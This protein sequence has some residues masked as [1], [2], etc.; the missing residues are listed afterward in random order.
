[1]YLTS[2]HRRVGTRRPVGWE[3][4]ERG[5]DVD[6]RAGQ[7]GTRAQEVLSSAVGLGGQW[8]EA[9]W[10]SS[11]PLSMLCFRDLVKQGVCCSVLI[12]D[13]S[14]CRLF[15]SGVPAA[16]AAQPRR[17]SGE[18]AWG[19]VC[20]PRPTGTDPAHW[21]GLPPSPVVAGCPPRG[22]WGPLFLF[23]YFFCLPFLSACLLCPSVTLCPP[24][25]N[26]EVSFGV[27]NPLGL[28]QEPSQPLNL[29]AK[30]KAPELPN[31]SSSPSLKMSNCGPRPPSHGAPTRDLQASPPSL[32]LGKPPLHLSLQPSSRR[33]LRGQDMTLSVSLPLCGLQFL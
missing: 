28:P 25:H 29:T 14:P 16:A 7:W 24:S 21:P 26:V 15:R 8:L 5:E 30:P 32:P 12:Q 10:A 13:F 2:F 17:P 9:S 23:S 1:M 31:A 6:Q 19:L 27:S 33:E 3:G 20:P 4:Q 18:E 11:E 22:P